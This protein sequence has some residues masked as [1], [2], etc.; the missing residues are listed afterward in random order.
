MAIAAVDDDMTLWLIT[1][2]SS[3][4]VSEIEDDGRAMLTLQRSHQFAALNGNIELIYERDKIWE[5]WRESYRIWYEGKSDPDIVLLRFA[6]YDAEYWDSSGAKGIAYAF[7]AVRAYMTG[8]K[9]SDVANDSDAHAKVD[10][11]DAS[12]STRRQ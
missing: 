12:I 3:P 4:K 1:S 10:V 8:E 2:A 7:Q 6:P 9:L 5:L 11:Y